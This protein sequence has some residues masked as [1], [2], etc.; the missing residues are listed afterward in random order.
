MSVRK[1]TDEER[2]LFRESV[3]ASRPQVVVKTAARKKPSAKAGGVERGQ[4]KCEAVFRAAPEAPIVK[5]GASAPGAARPL[6]KGLDGNTSEKLKRGQLAPGARI[7]LHGLTEDR[8]HQ[9]LLSFV[10]RAQGDGVKLALV[11]TG[12]GYPKDEEGAPWTM[13]SHGVLKEMVPRWLNEKHF[14][15]LI[16]GSGPAHRRHGGDGALYVYLRKIR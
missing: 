10:R 15:A 4:E 14:A 9:A 13:R 2:V 7:D 1:I 3:E 8:A 11:I 12:K 5:L 16:A 6:K